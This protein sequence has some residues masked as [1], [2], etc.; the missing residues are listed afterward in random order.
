M[1]KSQEKAEELVL[2]YL[3][4]NN[5]TKEWFNIHIAKQCALIAVDEIIK[6]MSDSQDWYWEELKQEIEKL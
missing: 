5:N 3:R 1:S 2:K 6:V 4:I